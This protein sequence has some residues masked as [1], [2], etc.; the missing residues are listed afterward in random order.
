MEESPV[1][2]WPDQGNHGHHRILTGLKHFLEA[3]GGSRLPAR[4]GLT[5][6]N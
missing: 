5:A 1:S 3:A 2:W 4:R 6:A